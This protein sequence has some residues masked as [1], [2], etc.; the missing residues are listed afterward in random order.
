M[1]QNIL[2][3]IRLF[4]FDAHAHTVDGWFYE[5]FFILV[6]GDVERIE[7]DFGGT[8]GFNLWDIMALRGLGGKVRKRKG[9]GK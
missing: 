8:G 3:V 2:D 7:E 1:Y 9:G 5:D 6:S 4:Y